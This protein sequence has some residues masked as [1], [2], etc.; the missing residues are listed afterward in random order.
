M[1]VGRL[2]AHAPAHVHHLELEASALAKRF[3]PRVDALHESVPLRARVCN[4]RMTDVPAMKPQWNLTAQHYIIQRKPDTRGVCQKKHIEVGKH[5]FLRR[6]N[7]CRFPFTGKHR[8]QQCSSSLVLKSLR[9]PVNVELVKMRTMRDVSGYSKSRRP[10]SAA[11]TM[12]SFRCCWSGVGTAG[13]GDP[14]TD[15][16]WCRNS[17]L[18][19]RATMHSLGWSRSISLH[20]PNSFAIKC[21][22]ACFA[23]DQN[24]R[25]TK[26]NSN[27]K[28]NT[29]RLRS[30]C[31]CVVNRRCPGTS[32]G[33]P[34]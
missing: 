16:A 31:V 26:G 30:N 18:M 2:V 4:T 29:N 9:S 13:E 8:L 6:S 14:P 15:S 19:C 12:S 3:E 23:C 27:D 28:D 24:S 34:P 20:P 17:R 25:N 11:S 21:R 5:S 10:R 33:L 7:A 1:I 22:S 32:P